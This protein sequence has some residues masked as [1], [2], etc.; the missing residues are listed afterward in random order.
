MMIE[1][2]VSWIGEIPD[3]WEIGR[4]KYY[5][6]LKGRIGWQGLTVDEYTEEGPYLITGIDFCNGGI[7][8]EDCFH[9]SKERY[10]QA[11]EI[12]IKEGDLL[13]TKDGTIGKVAVVS[14][15]PD[16]TTLNSGVMVIRNKKDKINLRFMYYVLKSEE[17][18]RWFGDINAGATTISHLYQH[19]LDNFKFALPPKP[20]QNKIADILDNKVGRAEKVI[21]VLKKELDVLEKTKISLITEMVTRGINDDNEL[22]SIDL[23]YA[24]RKPQNWIYT[25]IKYFCK[26]ES[27]DNIVS[28]IIEE[29]GKYPVYGGNGLRGYYEKYTNDGEHVL[30]GRQGA[31]CGNIHLVH[32]K[33]WATD[34]AV[35]TYARKY[36][37]NRYLYYL[38]TAVNFNKYSETAAQPGLS[39]KKIKNVHVC[40]PNTV[41]EQ[42]AIADI[43]DTKC[44]A[45]DQVIAAKKTQIEKM[46]E[47]KKTLIYDYVTGVKRVKG[48]I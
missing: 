45:F 24:D 3:D 43:L 31:L 10:D 17:F 42:E 4:L 11:P 16:K 22:V 40:V 21:E 13:I 1:T 9:V 14:N 41:E 6:S 5:L 46:E 23:D 15:M 38:F 26:L 12:M 33:F 2:S 19:D 29:E 28:E 32:G 7:D 34:H 48:A 25:R 8:W 18:W 47:Y 35:V 39:V 37:S 30:I 36:M 20:E 27:G 44:K